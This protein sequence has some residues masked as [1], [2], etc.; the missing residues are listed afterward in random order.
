ML[1]TFTSE[2][3]KSLVYTPNCNIVVIKKMKKEKKRK[4]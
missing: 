3:I 1:T 2:R 4:P